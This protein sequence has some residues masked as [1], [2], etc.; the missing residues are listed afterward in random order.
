MSLWQ[1]TENVDITQR[2]SSV[3]WSI[4]H[5]ANLYDDAR[6][7]MMQGT[8]KLIYLIYHILLADAVC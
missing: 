8:Q 6:I 5:I 1:W 3:P 4:S 2:T 7:V